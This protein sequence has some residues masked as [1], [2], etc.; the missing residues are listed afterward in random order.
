[1]C[2][3][4]GRHLGRALAAVLVLLPVLG[5]CAACDKGPSSVSPVGYRVSADGHI[6]SLLVPKGP[7]DEIVSAGASGSGGDVVTVQSTFN[8]TRTRPVSW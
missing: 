7:L 5:T 4:N 1:M 3:R 6:L 2:P 8:G